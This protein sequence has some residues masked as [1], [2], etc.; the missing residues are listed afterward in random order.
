MLT[1]PCRSRVRIVLALRE[2]RSPPCWRSPFPRR[3]ETIRYIIWFGKVLTTLNEDK[4]FITHCQPHS[5]IFTKK[6]YCSYDLKQLKQKS[7]KV[8]KS[9]NLPL[10][11]MHLISSI[12]GPV[13]THVFHILRISSSYSLESASFIDLVMNTYFWGFSL[14]CLVFHDII[15]CLNTEFGPEIFSVLES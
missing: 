11:F 14:L 3:G 12:F 5:F 7:I 8:C 6:E 2:T 10:K 15:S 9:E 1:P 13:A 4:F